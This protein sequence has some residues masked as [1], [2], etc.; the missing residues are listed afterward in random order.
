MSL[1]LG[2]AVIIFFCLKEKLHVV[3]EHR[4]QA[5]QCLYVGGKGLELPVVLLL[6]PSSAGVPAG[7]LFLVVWEV[8][9]S[10]VSLFLQYLRMDG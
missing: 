10:P 6:G 1:Q 9:G 3:K 5:E 4:R 8:G 2:R 7:F